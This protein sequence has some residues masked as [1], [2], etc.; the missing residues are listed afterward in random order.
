MTFLKKNRVMSFINDLVVDHATPSNI[1]YYWNLGSISGLMLAVQVGSGVFLAMHYVPHIDYAFL[2]IEHIMRDVSYGWAMRYIH[3]NGAAFFFVAVYAH[4]FRAL[5]YG[6]FFAGGHETWLIGVTIYIVMMAT[7]FLGYVLPWG[8]MSLWG[9]TV[10]TNFFSVIPFIGNTVVAWLW[11]GFSVNNATL[12]RF[13]SLHFFLPFI[14]IFL[15][16][17][18][19]LSLHDSG[20]GNPVSVK[21]YFKKASLEKQ[22]GFLH[23]SFFPY[24]VVKDALGFLWFLFVFIYIV[25]FT[26]NLLGHPDNYIPAN[27]L[28]TPS[29]IV[30]EWYFLPFYAILRSVPNKAAG[31]MLMFFSFLVFYFIKY[32]GDF[33]VPASTFRP[34]YRQFTFFFAIVCFLLGWIGGNPVE[35]PYV[36]IGQTCT[37]FYF[38][39]FLFC[40]P[41]LSKLEAINL[42][43]YEKNGV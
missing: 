30:P 32:L 38:A 36:V 6:L 24:F 27:P 4:M 14:L 18:H 22:D 34:V 33:L 3:A 35:P 25:A 11:G 26:P 7:A 2:S 37:F 31:I 28:V 39:F 9:A 10:I 16:F 23:V 40:L 15:V 42:V 21:G 20:H 5:Y 13:F 17:L 43:D 19:L 8:Q 41:V 12:N 1:S 29:H